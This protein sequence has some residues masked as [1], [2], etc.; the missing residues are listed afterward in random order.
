MDWRRGLGVALCGAAVL[1]CAGPDAPA[2]SGPPAR[3][4]NEGGALYATSG[5]GKF[6]AT[7]ATGAVLEGKFAFTARQYADGSAGGEFHQYRPDLDMLMWG[8]V[9]C[10]TVD[11][12]ERRAWVGG[13]ITKVQS[14]NPAVL[15]DPVLQPG[16]DVWF[17]VVD[18]GEGADAPPDRTTVFGFEGV[19]PSSAEYCRTQPWPAGDARTWPV[20]SGNIQVR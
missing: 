16:R 8:E 5:G 20:T 3:L 7:L 18:Y 1:G 19:I 6:L 9:T 15:A 14:D 10:L 13:V 12:V 4:S 17:R 2:P 11:P